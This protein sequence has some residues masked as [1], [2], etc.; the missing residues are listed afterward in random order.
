MTSKQSDSRHLQ[1][2]V[3]LVECSVKVSSTLARL[4]RKSAEREA[5]GASAADALLAASGIQPGEIAQLRHDLEQHAEAAAQWRKQAEQGH[6]LVVQ[7]RAAL[8]QR[9]EEIA[10]LQGDLRI[11]QS[12]LAAEQHQ[13]HSLETRLAE[14][15]ASLKC[16]EQQLIKSISVLDLGPDAVALME[17]FRSH[18]TEYDIR[19]PDDTAA[20]QTVISNLT[21]PEMSALGEVLDRAGWRLSLIRWLL[22]V[23]G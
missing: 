22:R 7:S 2:A 12:A 13:I 16:Q 8:A 23:Q 17:L 5:G 4:I 21:R 3:A 19:Y 9:E 14:L 15:T 20:A 11:T 18:L 6:S 1:P 10:N